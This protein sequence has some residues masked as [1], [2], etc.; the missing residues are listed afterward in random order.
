MS[1]PKKNF[2]LPL[3]GSQH[4]RGEGV[5]K[6][7]WRLSTPSLGITDRAENS[8]LHNERQSDFQLPLSGS[9]TALRYSFTDTDD[10]LSTPSLGITLTYLGRPSLVLAAA[11]NSLSRDHG[12]GDTEARGGAGTWHFQLPLSGSLEGVNK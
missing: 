9:L 5:R 3:S 2:Q 10:V 12:E 4:T 7:A 8:Y 6:R 11:F 1:Q